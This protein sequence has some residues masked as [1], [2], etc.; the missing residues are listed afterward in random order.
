MHGYPGKNHTGDK[1]KG[2]L[3][4]KKREKGRTEKN[5]KIKRKIYNSKKR[6]EKKEQNKEA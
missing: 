6:G 4:L 2:Y 5:G 3:F 1:G